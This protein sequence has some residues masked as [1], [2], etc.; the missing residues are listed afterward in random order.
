MFEKGTCFTPLRDGI[1]S[2]SELSQ[3]VTLFDSVQ[4]SREKVI[5]VHNDFTSFNESLLLGN[6]PFL[7][8][9]YVSMMHSANFVTRSQLRCDG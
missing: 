5:D 2:D 7:L 9:A 6:H 8:A 4:V 3:H 1:F